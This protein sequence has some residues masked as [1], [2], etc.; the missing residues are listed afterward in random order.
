[1]E[2]I[3]KELAGEEEIGLDENTLLKIF[4]MKTEKLMNLSKFNK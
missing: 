1:M 3:A 2:A 4:D